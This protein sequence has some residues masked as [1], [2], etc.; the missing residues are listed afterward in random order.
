MLAS[1]LIVLYVRFLLDRVVFM[2]GD[3]NGYGCA[4]LM[5]AD[6]KLAPYV[7]LLRDIV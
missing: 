4:K 3:H 2:Q 7:Y 6:F 5:S 1:G